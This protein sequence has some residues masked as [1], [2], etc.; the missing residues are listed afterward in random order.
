MAKKR[1][2]RQ[3]KIIAD[4]R[5]QLQTQ[6]PLQPSAATTVASTYS[7]PQ[8]KPIVQPSSHT[9]TSN[10]KPNTLVRQQADASSAYTYVIS[11]LKKTLLFTTIAIAAQIGLYIILTR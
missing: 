2:T 4:L 11:D 6:E 3:E 1:K 10:L 8:A 9:L 5:R 7:L